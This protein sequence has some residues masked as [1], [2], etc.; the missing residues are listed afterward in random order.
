[1]FVNYPKRR[2]R[3]RLL[4]E[5]RRGRRRPLSGRRRQRLSGRPGDVAAGRIRTA[6]KQDK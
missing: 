4:L 6:S 1:M 2:G 5:R 3:G